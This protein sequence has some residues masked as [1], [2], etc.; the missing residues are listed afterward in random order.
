MDSLIREALEIAI[1]N[2]EFDGEYDKV[3][4]AVSI[5]KEGEGMTKENLIDLLRSIVDNE[6]QTASDKL[7]DVK[8]L[9]RGENA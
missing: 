6:G 4:Q 5:I 2:W 3:S 8:E 1:S 9:L 7:E